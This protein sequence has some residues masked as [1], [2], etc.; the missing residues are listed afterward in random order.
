MTSKS[1]YAQILKASSIMGGAA[2]INLLL[3]MLR[4]KFAAVFIGTTGVGLISSFGALQGLVGTLAGLGIQSSAVREIAA[5]VGKGDDQ[6][7]GRAVLAL[8]RICWLTGLVGMAA[9]M[10]LAPLLSQLT[11]G[12][13]DYT[14]DIAALGVII[15]FGNL[16]GGQMALIQ[17]MRRI[18]DMAR[19][20]IYGAAAGTVAAIGFYAALGLRGI[21]PTLLAVSAIQLALSFHFARRVPVPEV[22]LTWRQ[23]FAEAGDVVRLGLVMMWNG[24]MGSAVAYLTV[25]LITQHEGTQAVGL[26][27][28]AFALSGMFVNFVLGAMGADYYPRLTGVASDKPAMVRMVNEQTEIGLLL[29]LPGLLATMALAPW[30]LQIFYTREFLGAVELLQ[31]FILG[32]LGR[33]ISWPLGFVMLAL[34]KGKWFLVTET[35]SNLLHA[36]LIAAGLHF[37]GIEGVAVAFFVI[38]LAYILTVYLVCR[39]LI[40]FA[41]SSAC[42]RITLFGLPTLGATF[43]ACRNLPLW[44]GTAVGL[45]LTLLVSGF[46]LRKLAFL[47]G[48]DHRIIQLVLRLTGAKWLLFSHRHRLP[49]A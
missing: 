6:A 11:F 43:I 41:W 30:I 13:R 39:H 12:H 1:S 45:V 24:L 44:P 21:I 29:A 33:V 42:A 48:P 19:A 31:W 37:L 7:V 16:S 38:Y 20:N 4:V 47:L 46:C 36:A 14:L 32:C 25:T 26:Y 34:G 2:G 3:G 27:S 40:S 15:L 28:A 17:G 35:G 8:R 9:M 23:T 10:L 22:S 5:A 49:P 18:G